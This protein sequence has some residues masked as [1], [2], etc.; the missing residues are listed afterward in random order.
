MRSQKLAS[1]VGVF[2]QSTFDVL[3][4]VRARGCLLVSSDCAKMVAD[5]AFG[6]KMGET[7]AI[8][9][10]EHQ[11]GEV[12]PAGLGRVAG[13]CGAKVRL[14]A[15]AMGANAGELSGADTNHQASLA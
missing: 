15:T 10:A 12:A 1:E 7:L 2:E 11:T 8:V 13:A 6:A 3:K 5:Q 9:E 14:E 4:G